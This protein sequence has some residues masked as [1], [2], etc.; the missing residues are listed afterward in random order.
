MES[1]SPDRHI[2]DRAKNIADLYRL[3]ADV[4]GER[5]AQAHREKG[6]DFSSHSYRELYEEACALGTVFIELGLEARQHVTIVS[7]NRPEWLLVDAAVL[8]CGAADVP[9]AADTTEQE[10]SFIVAHSDSVLVVAE[11]KNV[12]QRVLAVRAAMPKVKH[13]VLMEGEPPEGSGVLKLEELLQQGRRLWEDGDRRIVARR[14]GI[15]GE[16]LFTII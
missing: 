14:E 6:G 16:D 1:A 11:N 13:I 10:V 15:R 9:R 2:Y 7:D 4:Y 8:L 5:P 3:V 12:L